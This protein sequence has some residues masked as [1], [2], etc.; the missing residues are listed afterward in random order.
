MWT[1]YDRA[2]IRGAIEELTGSPKRD[3]EALAKRLPPVEGVR[4]DEFPCSVCGETMVMD[5]ETHA[6]GQR[7][8]ALFACVRCVCKAKGIPYPESVEVQ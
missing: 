7:M 8:G 2:A 6:L 3:W 1:E 4:F 5:A